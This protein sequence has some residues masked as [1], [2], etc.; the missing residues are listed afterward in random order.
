M[1]W[2]EPISRSHH[3]ADRI[4][5]EYLNGRSGLVKK[6]NAKGSGI[7]GERADNEMAVGG[8]NIASAKES[9]NPE[10]KTKT[11]SNR[12]ISSGHYR[13]IHIPRLAVTTII[14]GE[15]GN[16]KATYWGAGRLE[17]EG[18]WCGGSGGRRGRGIKLKGRVGG[19][20][21]SAY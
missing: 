17:S 19:G 11:I 9:R 8:Q 2:T 1:E 5:L 20:T 10:L 16:G 21:G 12:P 14:K 6:R 13:R 4:P 3:N 7:E 15:F 18:P